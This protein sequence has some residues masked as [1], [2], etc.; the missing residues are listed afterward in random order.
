MSI[1]T[2]QHGLT[3]DSLR[4]FFHYHQEG[5]H[6]ELVDRLKKDFENSGHTVLTRADCPDGGFGH[7][8]L[9]VCFFS[10][11][12]GDSKPFD[13]EL[14]Q[15]QAA[16]HAV[17]PVLLDD[18]VAIPPAIQKTQWQDLTKQPS[19]EANASGQNWEQWYR[20]H[21]D[22]MLAAIPKVLHEAD[23]DIAVLREVL[24]P[25]DFAPQLAALAQDFVPPE[26]TLQAYKKW[27]DSPP[28]KPCL[29][30]LKA[31]SG[32]DRTAFAAHLVKTNAHAVVGHWFAAAQQPQLCDPCHAVRT[33]AFQLAQRLPD[34]R[35][36][37]LQALWPKT[38]PADVITPAM[39]QQ[40]REELAGKNTADLFRLYITD[41]LQK[42]IDPHPN[43]LVVV[44]DALDQMEDGQGGNPFV[45]GCLA[46]EKM[47]TLPTW[48]GFMV[49]SPLK[50]IFVQ[51][52]QGRPFITLGASA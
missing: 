10:K 7:S 51:R 3:A 24:T 19:R 45:V 41:P 38:S 2:N 17:L 12:A 11:H 27:R 1:S 33:L 20:Q 23:E 16:C 6:T 36:G 35:S 8:Q 52:L 47:D 15:A 18:G 30:L 42:H 49:T 32:V 4:I 29:Q 25:E 39:R 31:E 50:G 34:Y 37:L 26:E 44:L 5:A 22:A 13:A 43:R 9:C 21:C 14:E 40:K 46:R 28:A 48:L